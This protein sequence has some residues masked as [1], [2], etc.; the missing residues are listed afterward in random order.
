[1]DSLQKKSITSSRGFTY[2][3]Y[4]SASTPASQDTPPL[5]LMHGFPDDSHLWAGIVSRLPQYRVIVPDMLGY[6]GTS[7]PT[8]PAAY[9]Y[10]AVSQDL[11]EILDAEGVS[12]AV[13]AGHDWGSAVAQ[14]FYAHRPERVSAL[15]LLNVAY[16]LPSSEPFDLDATNAFTEKTFGR[17]LLAY[18][19][20]LV[21]KEGPGILRQHVGRL[22]DGMHGAPRDFFGELLCVRGNFKKWLLNEGGDWNVEARE[23]AKDQG[24]KRRYVERLE[25]DGFEAPV[26]YYLANTEHVQHKVEKDMPREKF[27]VNV[28]LLYFMCSQDAVCRPEMMIPAKMGGFVPDLEEVTL[29]CSHWSPLEAPEPIASAL[30]DFVKRKIAS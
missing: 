12:K 10:G 2:T 25:R 19:E 22:W 7:K 21:S 11:A 24:L 28:P 20:L 6:G 18:Q 3:Y 17:P 8:D 27:V 26:C 29:D 30:D 15:V 4:V 23:Y 5:F 14:R 1:M 9:E 16:L 13:T